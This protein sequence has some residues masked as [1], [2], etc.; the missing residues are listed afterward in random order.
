MTIMTRLSLYLLTLLFAT[1]LSAQVPESQIEKQAREMELKII[2]GDV[3]LPLNLIQAPN[4]FSGDVEI[5][6]E[7]VAN[8]VNQ[9]LYFERFGKPFY[10]S[11]LRATL[12]SPLGPMGLRFEEADLIFTQVADVNDG[13]TKSQVSVARGDNK[14]VI[15]GEM[16]KGY[17]LPPRMVANL[18]DRIRQGD[19]FTFLTGAREAGIVLR[20]SKVNI[21][22]PFALFKPRFTVQ[23]TSPGHDN[24]ASWQ[25]AKVSRHQLQYVRYDP[26]DSTTTKVLQVYN[27]PEKY[28]MIAIPGFKSEYRFWDD[29]EYTVHPRHVGSIDTLRKEE[30][31]VPFA[32]QDIFVDPRDSWVL[33][34]G[35][36]NARQ[37][38]IFIEPDEF[39][40]ASKNPI[41]LVNR[42]KKYPI[43]QTLVSVSPSD[44]NGPVRQYILDGRYPEQWGDLFTSRPPNTSFYFE[45]IIVELEPGKLARMWLP[46]VICAW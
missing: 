2:W 25:T 12:T 5:Q 4:I 40:N 15:E 39:S 46:F 30:V 19:A 26:D 7:D 35:T 13:T 41:F 42:D 44:D 22:S 18:M 37:D 31:I 24:S 32:F 16:F 27:D 11:N 29:A 10:V 14:E 6:I 21:Y 28:K 8:M 20:E 1:S 34:W 9:P 23:K 43:V 17:V 38:F 45:D 33:E 3:V 36:I